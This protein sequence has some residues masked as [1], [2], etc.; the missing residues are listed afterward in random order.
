[1]TELKNAAR[2]RLDKGELSLG[3]GIRQA[4]TVDIGM[5]MQTAGF[6]WLF[7]DMEH[8]SM[9]IDMAAQISVAAQSAGIAPLVRVPGHED[10]HASRA[11]DGGAMGIVFPHVDDAETALRVASGCRYPPTGRRSM[12]GTIA[13]LGFKKH[14]VADAASLVNDAVLVVVMIE[15]ATG[16]ENA[17]AIAATP[18]V[19]VVMIGTND[20]CLD[21]GIPG[22]FTHDRIV[23]AY[24]TLTAACK[25]HQKFAGMGGVYDPAQMKA[26]IDMGVRF[27]LSGS[28]MAF[29]M[30]GA[31]A[32]VNAA[33]SI[34]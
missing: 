32:Q 29:M 4:R 27:I 1:M 25:K 30:A 6:D 21:L 17:D 10:F 23:S 31:T 24:E 34:L 3:V 5:A 11:L 22:E 13:Q 7:I 33:R 2:E 14:S 28:D 18:G 19:D 16:L 8:N 15:T 20:L 9:S 12:A 26:Y